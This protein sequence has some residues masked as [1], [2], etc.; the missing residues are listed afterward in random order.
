M[1]WM[2]LVAGLLA[3]MAGLVWILQGLGM[4]GGSVMSGDRKWAII[5]A[6]VV[7]LGMTLT[8]YSLRRL[9]VGR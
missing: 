6:I 2:L 3:V 9:R 5:G 8:A 4:L 7:V 1:R